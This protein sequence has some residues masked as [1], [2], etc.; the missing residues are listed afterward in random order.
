M[1]GGCLLALLGSI[2][3]A[4]A[5][6]IPAMIAGMTLIGLGSSSQLSFVY[7]VSELV[8]IKYRFLANG[9]CYLFEIIPNGFGAVISYSFIYQT[10]VGWRGVFYLLIAL[11]ALC[12]ASWYF[13]YHPPTFGMK[14]GRLRKIQFL[15][16]FDYAGTVLGG[17]GLLLFLMGLSWGG[18]MYPWKSAHVISTVVIGFLL[19]VA[20]FLYETYMPLKE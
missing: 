2:V 11:N 3:C 14:H 12:T 7:T 6:N 17:L 20:F 16:D 18:V 4:T 1:I 8:P 5:P 10:S 9:Y 13:F 19:L 15:K